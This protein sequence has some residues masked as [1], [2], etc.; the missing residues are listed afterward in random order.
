[1]NKLSYILKNSFQKR[2][3]ITAYIVLIALTTMF[4]VQQQLRIDSIG[5]NN[6]NEPFVNRSLYLSGVEVT[7]PDNRKESFF[8][9]LKLCKRMKEMKTPEKVSFFTWVRY[10]EVFENGRMNSIPFRATDGTYWDVMK[11]RFVE[12]QPY[13]EE[14][15]VES[16]PLAVISETSRKRFFGNETQVVGRQIEIEGLRLTVCGVVKNV[17]YSSA[18]AFAEFW[19]PYTAWAGKIHGRSS[20]LDE[21]E[22]QGLYLVQTIARTSLDFAKIH[23]EYNTL[24]TGLNK[25]VESEKK[26]TQATLSTRMNYYFGKNIN[27]DKYK[28]S[29]ADILRNYLSTLWLLLIPLLALM[30]LNFA[31][32]NERSTEMG[33]RRMVGAGKPEINSELIIE[34]LVIVLIGITLGVFLGYITVYL[35]PFI[36]ISSVDA[37]N[38]EG[39]VWL[40]FTGRMFSHLLLTI[41]VFLAASVALPI[42]RVNRQSILN[43]LKGDEL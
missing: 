22:V 7:Y 30:C 29:V 8:A 11:F 21:N 20:A 31:R 38:L 16:K 23:Q 14:D 34:N 32:A 28:F 37:G 10:W 15:V 17:P 18:Y 39:G 42:A 2:F 19:I 33:I 40:P 1:M 4:V 9:G 36:F 26:I 27:Q 6:L 3:L 13:T 35:Y 41:V 12:G 43:L 5:A 25:E 24:I